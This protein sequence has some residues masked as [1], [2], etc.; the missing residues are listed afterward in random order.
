MAVDGAQVRLTSQSIQRVEFHPNVEYGF[1]LEVPGEVTWDSAELRRK[2]IPRIVAER[3]LIFTGDE[4]LDAARILL[5]KINASGGSAT[6]V[7]DAVNL[8]EPNPD[9]ARMFS[10]MATEDRRDPPWWSPATA[11]W[12]EPRARLA[13]LPAA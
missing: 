7:A 2:D 1:E 12:E 6:V 8:L 5:P 13:V 11:R 3:R 10:R 4:A 9:P